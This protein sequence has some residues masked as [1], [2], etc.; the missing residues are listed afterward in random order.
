MDGCQ[1]VS[2]S[3]CVHV[4]ITHDCTQSYKCM[5]STCTEWKMQTQV[6]EPFS[7]K[8]IL[9]LLEGITFEQTEK[10]GIFL[11][12][13]HN[14]IDAAKREYRDPELFGLNVVR[15][16]IDKWGFS[17][18]CIDTLSAAMKRCGIRSNGSEGNLRRFIF[19]PCPTIGYKN[20]PCNTGM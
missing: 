1:C 14:K 2:V 17:A 11:E 3:V 12:V 18:T 9:E 10:L 13:P 6:D 19:M 7:D 8:H 20:A 16:W 15:T 5:S 4:H